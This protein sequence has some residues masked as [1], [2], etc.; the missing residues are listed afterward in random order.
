MSS[1]TTGTIHFRNRKS[2]QTSS[3]ATL[4]KFWSLTRVVHFPVIN[5]TSFWQGHVAVS[6]SYHGTTENWHG[7]EW[8]SMRWWQLFA[9]DVAEAE[10]LITQCWWLEESQDP[11]QPS[12][13]G[14]DNLHVWSLQRIPKWP[15]M[16]QTLFVH[17]STLYGPSAP[18]PA[19][20]RALK[21]K[22]RKGDHCSPRCCW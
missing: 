15:S 14:R 21:R 6:N 19:P 3:T 16:S 17:P 20:R 4:R 1:E 9:F 22:K 8:Q 11:P 18:S 10:I 2:S 5:R 12:P 7:R 13:D